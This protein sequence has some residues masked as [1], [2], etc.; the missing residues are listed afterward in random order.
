MFRRIPRTIFLVAADR[1]IAIDGDSLGEHRSNP[2]FERPEFELSRA[3]ARLRRW[4][5]VVV[6][7]EPEVKVAVGVQPP[8][9]LSEKTLQPSKIF[10]DLREFLASVREKILD[11]QL[12]VVLSHIDR[13]RRAVAPAGEAK[14]VFY[15]IGRHEAA[16]PFPFF[17]LIKGFCMWRVLSS[18][19]A[20]RMMLRWLSSASFSTAATRSTR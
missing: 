9:R 11:S 3:P 20:A 2:L 5:K 15:G 12:R 8:Y 18:A 14:Y 10:V 6:L 16:L 4:K 17:C 7:P 19:S 13:E 1:D